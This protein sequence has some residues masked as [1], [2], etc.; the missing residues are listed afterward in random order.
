MARASKSWTTKL[1]LGAGAFVLAAMVPSAVSA[2]GE[3]I[4]A[5]AL[6]AQSGFTGFT[7]ASIDPRVA[8]IVAAQFAADRKGA[9]AQMMRFTPAGAG[10][11]GD[12]RSVT[13]AVRIDSQAARTISDRIAADGAHDLANAGLRIAPSRYNLGLARG[14]SSFAQAPVHAALAA[15]PSLSAAEIPDLSAYAPA[16]SAHD[17]PSRFAARVELDRAQTSGRVA[18]EPAAP[19]N[20]MLD[21]G[22]S[23]RLTR[24][25][26]VTA[27]VRYEQDRELRPLPDLDKLDSQA[28]YIGTQFRF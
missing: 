1:A 13:V 19:G 12:S 9:A 27:G 21:V 10:S 15:S 2:F 14:Y 4:G 11:W 24:N 26:D 22:G 28:V 25:L 20:Q 8:R 6:G 16:T 5:H 3:V 23:Y 17:E 7:P 18:D